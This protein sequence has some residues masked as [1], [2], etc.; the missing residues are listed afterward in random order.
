MAVFERRFAVTLPFG[1]VA[2]VALPAAAPLEADWPEALHEDERAF[3]RGLADGRR[4]SWLGGRMALRAALETAGLAVRGPILAT[5]RGG[6]RLPAGVSGSISHKADL[7]VAIAAPAGSPPV[8]LGIDL[9][10][11]RPLRADISARVLTEAER[12]A[13]PPAGPARAAWILRAFSA[14]EAIYKALDPWLRRFIGFQEAEV[15]VGPEGAM[16]GQL[17]LTG[18]EGPFAIELHD[19]GGVAGAGS[20]LTVATARRG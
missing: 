20:L 9:E 5:D 12:A 6:P 15:A 4:A 3:A 17:R 8:N 2:G 10:Q 18:G 16:S 13:L 7:A 11:P 19:L 14:K 1:A